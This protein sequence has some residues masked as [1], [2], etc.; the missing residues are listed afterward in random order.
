LLTIP[1]SPGNFQPCAPSLWFSRE[2][3]PALS[4]S[5]FGDVRWLVP[6]GIRGIEMK[7]CPYNLTISISMHRDVELIFM[8]LKSIMRETVSRI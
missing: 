6:M 7:K 4:L 1:A 5:G 3:D 8:S 2:L